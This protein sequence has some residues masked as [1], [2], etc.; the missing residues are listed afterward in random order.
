[1]SYDTDIDD[2]LDEIIR[3]HAKQNE[4][5]CLFTDDNGC[6]QLSPYDVPNEDV[7]KY[8]SLIIYHKDRYLE[9]L[10]ESQF[11]PE[12]CDQFTAYF[13]DPTKDE[14]FLETSR[15]II[16]RYYWD[17]FVKDLE[18]RL[19]SLASED[20]AQDAANDAYDDYRFDKDT[21]EVVCHLGRS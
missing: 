17:D 12:F 10:T 18:R 19:Q 2:F 6:Y 5:G 21:G 16:I 20:Y 3:Y 8:A 9:C 13:K 11:Y 1:M 7:A 14:D 4:H 15:K